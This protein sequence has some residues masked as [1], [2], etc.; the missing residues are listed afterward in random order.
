MRVSR[1]LHFFFGFVFCLALISCGG[2]GGS[3]RSNNNTTTTTNPMP[4]IQ[5]VS[6]SVVSIGSPDTTLTISGSNFVQGST[7][8]WNGTALTTTFVSSTQLT[9]SIP[10][11]ALSGNPGS[12]PV[13]V[14]NPTPGGGTSS[15]MAVALQ[16]PLPS[17]TSLSPNGVVLGSNGFTLTVN[18]TSFVSGA[19]VYWNSVSRVTTFVNSTQLT[20]TI[21]ASDLAV[22]AGTT[23]SVTVQNPTPS[24]GYSNVAQFNVEN[25]APVISF[26][27][28]NFGFAGLG[29]QVNITG[30]GFQQ[31]AVAQAAGITFNTVYNSATSLTAFV[32]TS[33][34]VGSLAVSVSNPAPSVG[35][36]NS[37]AFNNNAVGKPTTLTLVN[38]DNN[39]QIW[40]T[41]PGFMSDNA[42]YFAFQNF[43][44]D[45][46]LEGLAQC[47][48]S[49]ITYTASL[50]GQNY[51]IPGA[52]TPDGRYVP[53]TL[54]S[55]INTKVGDL[56]LADTCIGT[57]SGC[58]PGNQVLVP[59]NRQPNTDTVLGTITP[60][61]R[62]VSYSTFPAGNL[63][64]IDASAYVFDTCIG[65]APN[66]T[67]ASIPQESSTSG[68]IQSAI[69]PSSGHLYAVYTQPGL[70]NQGPSG[71][72]IYSKVVLRDTCLGA[73]PGCSPS[74][75]ILSDP[76]SD[77]SLPTITS[78]A[79]WVTY[80]CT[81]GS[82]VQNTCAGA[83]GS[84]TPTA[85]QVSGAT[86]LSDD[87][88]YVIYTDS[89]PTIGGHV[90]GTIP[91][92]AM[93]Y[94]TC[95][96]AASGCTPQAVPVCINSQGALANQACYVDQISADGKY[97]LFNSSATNLSSLLTSTINANNG[98][99]IAPNPLQ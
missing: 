21:L 77:C 74:D 96:G 48:P 2:G 32:S 70:T 46:C 65:A 25:P 23:A 27:T 12:V 78:N 3:T 4:A 41:S 14:T 93:V 68:T 24:P 66:C 64:N 72:D 30:T 86:G 18:G 42:R 52:P 29:T 53:S 87:G 44:R 84:C 26:I 36:S 31:G 83:S 56:E 55:G 40:T 81:N 61:G 94:D 98:W 33:A 91:A 45:T 69:D 22:S 90:A 58:T 54:Q 47:M 38:V 76:N 88:R 75:V 57:T 80:S 73:A 34:P 59:V 99:Y 60:G 7:V 37:L 92:T 97:I 20:A 13:T 63:N 35:P 95:N 82:F 16:Y 5:S 85:T 19:L 49:T 9:A 43:L 39:G 11:S 79:Q 50:S 6:P 67:P 15:S 1:W 10:A 8:M 17:I 51:Q 28:P 71:D 62:Y 89:S